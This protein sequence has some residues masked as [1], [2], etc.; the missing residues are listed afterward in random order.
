MIATHSPMVLASVEPD[1]DDEKD[2]IFTLRLNDGQAEVSKE[3]WA[4]QGDLVNWLVSDS[5]G[6]QQARSLRAEAAIEAAESWM[7]GDCGNLPDNLN[8]EK[9]INTELEKC[10]PSGD[11][12]WPRWIVWV[13]NLK[14]VGGDD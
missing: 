4:K 9:K 2:S 1:F 8:T 5:F 11:H 3:V 12:F 6:L 14:K 13:K 7:R 10:L